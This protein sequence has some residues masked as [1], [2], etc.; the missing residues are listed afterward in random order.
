MRERKRSLMSFLFFLRTLTYSTM[1]FFYK[2]VE[3]VSFSR[4]TCPNYT[5]FLL[6]TVLFKQEAHAKCIRSPAKRRYPELLIIT[7]TRCQ[8]HPIERIQDKSVT[9]TDRS[10]IPYRHRTKQGGCTRIAGNLKSWM[11]LLMAFN[12]KLYP[13]SMQ[14]VTFGHL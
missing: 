11:L 5:C 12:R 8:P 14:E 2:K 13:E 3:K 1:L 6:L 7:Y 10:F 4:W 9:R